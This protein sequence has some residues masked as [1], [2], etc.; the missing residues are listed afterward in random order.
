MHTRTSRTR[1][2]AAGGSSSGSAARPDAREAGQHAGASG[3]QERGEAAASGQAG[4]SRGKLAEAALGDAYYRELAGRRGNALSRI[5]SSWA[6]RVSGAAAQGSFSSQQAQYASGRTTRDYVCNTIGLALWGFVF[7]LLTIVCTQLVGAQQAGVFSLAFVTANLLMYLGN[8]GVRTFQ[9]A[10]I[11]DVRSFADYQVARIITCLAMLALGV[12]YCALRGYGGSVL[13]MT[14]GVFAYRTLDSLADVYEG[15]LQ[16]ADKMYLAGISQ[17]LRAGLALIAFSVVL[18]LSRSLAAAS[19]FLAIGNAL[20]LLF[21]TLPLA[22]METAKSRRATRANVADIMQRCLPLFAAIFLYNL[23]DNIPKFM[24]EGVLS[25]DN[26][27]YFNAL[28]FPAHSIL[29]M[30]GMVYKPLLLRLANAFK[31][32]DRSGFSSTLGLVLGCIVGIVVVMLVIMNTV[33]LPLMSFLYGIDFARFRIP[34]NLMIVAG[35]LTAAIDFLYQ[36][37][38]IQRKQN[39]VMKLYVVTLAVSV[40]ASVSLI[41][42]CGLLGAVAAYVIE[43]AVLFALIVRQLVLNSRVMR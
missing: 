42:A 10:D 41:H 18:L 40:V 3:S 2:R 25:Y 5:V 39:T 29:M 37:I 7:P 17:A 36:V 1:S 15:R 38:T 26:Q 43:M 19:V 9:V 13:V 24:M 14:L 11:Y 23:C 31:G 12:G 22:Y 28:Y 4:G 30:A 6:D 21:V 32:G 16:Q 34:M 27:L 8:Y 35:G 33:G 20:V